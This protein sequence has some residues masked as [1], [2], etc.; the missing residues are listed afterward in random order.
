MSFTAFDGNVT[1]TSGGAF[2]PTKGGQLIVPI[3][4]GE[5]RILFTQYTAG[6]IH[7][8]LKCGGRSEEAFE[9]ED[10]EGF[11]R[12]L[13]ERPNC[14]R[15]VLDIFSTIWELKEDIIA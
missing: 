7:W 10:P 15:K 1:I 4:K 11:E 13:K 2:D 14:W 9:M 5:K 8:W 6:G 12:M 3:P